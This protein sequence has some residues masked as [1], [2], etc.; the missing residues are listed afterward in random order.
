MIEIARNYKVDYDP[1]PSMFLVGFIAFSLPMIFA[2][3]Y[4]GRLFPSR[5]TMFFLVNPPLP[6]N[7][8]FQ[9]MSHGVGEEEGEG[10]EQGLCR[11]RRSLATSIPLSLSSHHLPQT[12][13]IIIIMCS[14]S[15]VQFV[16]FIISFSMEVH[17]CP[18]PT[19]AP[20]HSLP[21]RRIQVCPM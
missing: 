20:L 12:R 3:I 21:L 8:S 17:H 13:Y 4:P 6:Q 7:L 9:M 2:F 16:M 19:L 11:R 18:P 1:D 5:R 10:V 15:T 14:V